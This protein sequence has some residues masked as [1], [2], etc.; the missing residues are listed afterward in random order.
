[1]LVV[2]PPRMSVSAAV[3]IMKTNTSV[4]IKKKFPFLKK[5]Y[6]DDKGVWSVGYFVSTVG[7]NEAIIRRYIKLQEKE[8]SGQAQLAI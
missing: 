3:N 6:A 8:D 2:I 5:M 7:I 1:M 4:G